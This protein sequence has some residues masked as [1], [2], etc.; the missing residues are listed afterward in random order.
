MK[1]LTK[2]GT[3]VEIMGILSIRALL[4]SGQT[5][6]IMYHLPSYPK[7][8]CLKEKHASAMN[9][10]SPMHLLNATVQALQTL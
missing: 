10:I 1:L 7:R 5:A 3:T 8:T 4:R 6:S 9:P 2:K